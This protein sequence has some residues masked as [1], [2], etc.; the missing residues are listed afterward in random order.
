MP[1][2]PNTD[3]DY[4]SHNLSSVNNHEIIIEVKSQDSEPIN[5]PS[6]N[7]IAETLNISQCR[8]EKEALDRII[9]FSKYA[10]NAILFN[11]I[12]EVFFA[13]V[14]SCFGIIAFV[15]ANDCDRCALISYII[16]TILTLAA[17]LCLLYYLLLLHKYIWAIFI[18]ITFVFNVITLVVIFLDIYVLFCEKFLRRQCNPKRFNFT[19]N[20]AILASPE[21]GS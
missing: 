18:C 19:L 12:P 10:K 16:F 1:E 14:F 4:N 17:K 2:E 15:G 9:R 11:L 6:E 20:P 21:E 5:N 13:G 3:D 7:Q 8:D